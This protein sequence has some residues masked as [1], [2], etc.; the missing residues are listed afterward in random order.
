M[1]GIED[2]AYKNIIKEAQEKIELKVYCLFLDAPSE[3][4]DFDYNLG[5]FDSSILTKI[6]PDFK[7]R[8]FYISGPSQMVKEYKKVLV[9]NNVKRNQIRTDYFPGYA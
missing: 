9:L 7:Y 2:I 1:R 6:I 8:I 5:K 3:K 4:I